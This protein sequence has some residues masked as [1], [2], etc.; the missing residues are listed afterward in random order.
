M[1]EKENIASM[2]DLNKA[3]MQVH[4]SDKL[5]KCQVVK[6][7]GQSYVMTR[8]GFGLNVAPKIMS[9]II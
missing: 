2:L 5:K 9:R 6:Y 4:V 1:A 3:Y 8:M 7:K